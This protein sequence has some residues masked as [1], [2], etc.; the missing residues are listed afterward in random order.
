MILGPTQLWVLPKLTVP[1]RS[2]L[3]LRGSKSNQKSVGYSQ[4]IHAIIVP[5]GMFCWT[6]YCI[7]QGSQ[8]DKIVDDFSP[9]VAFIA[10]ST[11]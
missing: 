1:S 9:P 8:L 7:S 3:L 11:L 4:S 6:S 2:F 5:V 10:P